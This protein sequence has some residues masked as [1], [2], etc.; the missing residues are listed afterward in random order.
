M[1]LNSLVTNSTIIQRMC[2]CKVGVAMSWLRGL[3][4]LAIATTDLIILVV[5]SWRSNVLRIEQSG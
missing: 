4:K 2:W 5:H 1:S 3:M